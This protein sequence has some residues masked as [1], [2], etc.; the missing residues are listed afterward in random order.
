MG[1]A[2]FKSKPNGLRKSW[3]NYVVQASGCSNAW[4]PIDSVLSYLKPVWCFPSTFKSLK[5]YAAAVECALPRLARIV[6]KHGVTPL[7]SAVIYI[8][9]RCS[10]TPFVFGSN[11]PLATARYVR[12]AI[13]TARRRHPS[14]RRVQVESCSHHSDSAT[15]GKT[16]PN[17]EA[18]KRGCG[19]FTRE[20]VGY[21]RETWPDLEVETVCVDELES[22][23]RML[24]ASV[25][26]M[27]MPSSFSFVPGALKGRD[28]ITPKTFGKVPA[29]TSAELAAL[30]DRVPWTMY[31]GAVETDVLPTLHV[32]NY[33]QFDYRRFLDTSEISPVAVGA[34]I[35]EWSDQRRFTR[36]DEGRRQLGMIGAI[37]VV[38]VVVALFVP[39]CAVVFGRSRRKR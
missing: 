17:S 4:L 15:D 2:M 33:H 16:V 28:F 5:K 29:W 8:H 20:F 27:T 9:F 18:R 26:I 19:R 34:S 39:Y 30:P 24:G 3:G 13:E 35:V 25:L 10:D 36:R 32:P 7:D 22:Q 23:R 14:V 11:Y 6:A 38:V 1:A 21:L 31:R 12:F 37:V